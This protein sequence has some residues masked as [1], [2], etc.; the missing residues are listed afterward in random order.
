M[1]DRPTSVL[2]LWRLFMNP[3]SSKEA[4]QRALLAVPAASTMTF[5]A[6]PTTTPADVEDLESGTPLFL[7]VKLPLSKAMNGTVH[8][9]VA[10]VSVDE[11]CSGI[12]NAKEVRA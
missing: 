8:V 12:F 2:E 1:A 5:E 6:D 9:K 11:F 4:C 7:S 3:N 10:I